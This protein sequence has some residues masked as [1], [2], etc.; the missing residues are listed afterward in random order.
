MSGKQQCLLL[1]AVPLFFGWIQ[2]KRPEDKA[3]LTTGY[4]APQS[5]FVF[6]YVFE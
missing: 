2:E 1:H 3:S 4:K 5:C 6:L